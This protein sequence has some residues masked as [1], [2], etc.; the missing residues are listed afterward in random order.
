M[1]W[2]ATKEPNFLFSIFQNVSF[3]LY[4]VG[5]QKLEYIANKKKIQ[6]NFS[7][8]NGKGLLV[9]GIT[10]GQ[11]VSWWALLTRDGRIH[12]QV[13]FMVGVAAGYTASGMWHYLN[14]IIINRQEL[15]FV[16]TNIPASDVISSTDFFSL[17]TIFCLL[18][19]FVIYHGNR[20]VPTTII[21]ININ[22]TLTEMIVP[23]IFLSFLYCQFT[24]CYFTQC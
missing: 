11:D 14:R 6:N 23:F 19:D 9:S 8:A 18:N 10:S 12:E 4:L 3:S 24:I 5:D 20:Q 7:L 15:P 21:I 17:Q 22:M 1:V 13:V 16:P 2:C